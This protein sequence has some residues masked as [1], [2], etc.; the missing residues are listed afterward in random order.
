MKTDETRTLENMRSEILNEILAERI[1]QIKFCKDGGD[2]N[3]FDKTNT[4]NDWVAFI[5]AY[6]GRASS[7]VFRNERQLEDFRTNMIKV[8]ALSLAAIE[9]HD[10]GL[11]EP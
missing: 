10:Q 9:A 4:K 5:A 11:C 8:A 6:A 1:R 7:K 2:T 3:A